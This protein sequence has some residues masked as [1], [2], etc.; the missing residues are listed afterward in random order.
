VGRDPTQQVDQ[1]LV[2][3]RAPSVKR[4]RL[5]R[6]SESAKVVEVSMV[7]VRN[8]SPSGLNGTRAMPKLGLQLGDPLLRRRQLGVLFRRAARLQA[9]VDP[10]LSGK[11]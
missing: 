1:C 7:P 2:A 4:G 10:V 8:P 9:A 3:A 11:L 6:R 5:L